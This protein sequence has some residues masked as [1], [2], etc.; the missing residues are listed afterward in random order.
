LRGKRRLRR[1]PPLYLLPVFQDGIE[2]GDDIFRGYKSLD[3]VDSG[4]YKAAAWGQV[5]NTPS[6][7]IPYFLR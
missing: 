1:S 5:V 4:K 7:L 3:F 6:D 2:G